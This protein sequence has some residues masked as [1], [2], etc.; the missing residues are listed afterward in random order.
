VPHFRRTA[1]CL[2]PDNDYVFLELLGFNP[3]VV[4]PLDA[5]NGI[6]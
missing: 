2:G 3:E 4:K 1:P 6:I 5:G